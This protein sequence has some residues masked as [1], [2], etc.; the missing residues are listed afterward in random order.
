MVTVEFEAANEA[1]SFFPPAWF[2]PEVTGDAAYG[3][4]T[5]ALNGVAQARDV[6]LS[7]AALDS[8]LDVLENRFSLARFGAASARQRTET[9]ASEAPPRPAVVPT[10]RPVPARAR[11]PQPVPAEP[12]VA[13]SA[14]VQPVRAQVQAQAPVQPRMH[15]ASQAH[16]LAPAIAEEEAPEAA[17]PA[18]DDSGRFDDVLATLSRALVDPGFLGNEAAP[19]R[20]VAVELDR[21]ARRVRREER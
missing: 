6:A 12:A 17:Q 16:A 21:S 13:D 20:P 19:T 14:P 1:S 2:G 3:K 5:L 9:R 10:E 8:L 4:R 15:A 11:E 7:N 18:S